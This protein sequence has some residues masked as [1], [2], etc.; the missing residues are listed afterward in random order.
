MCEFVLR[1]GV[2]ASGDFESLGEWILVFEMNGSNKW[3]LIGC[4]DSTTCINPVF[5]AIAV[6]AI[7]I[8]VAAAASIV[9]YVM[10]WNRVET[11]SLLR[12]C[13][14]NSPE[15]EQLNKSMLFS[16]AHIAIMFLPIQRTR[17]KAISLETNTVNKVFVSLTR[18]RKKL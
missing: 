12:R 4:S 2:D 16:H 11:K 17:I 1:I 5:A 7:F 9:G 3:D 6:A 18:V 8:T 10:R 13:Y 14:Q 15:E